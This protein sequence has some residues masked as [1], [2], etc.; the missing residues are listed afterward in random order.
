MEAND[1][2]KEKFISGVWSEKV[3][4]IT[5]DYEITGFVF[6]PKTGKRSRVLSD[7]LNSK[8]RFVAVKD[9]ELKK[10]NI[11][12]DPIE[13]HDFIQVN[14]DSIIILRPQT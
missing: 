13:K 7:I 12:T 2:I 14:L 5:D 9:C 8:R 11:P 10:R 3:L 1:T 4:I 6:M